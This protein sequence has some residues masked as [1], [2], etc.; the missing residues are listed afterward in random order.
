MTFGC[1]ICFEI[2]S[3]GVE[4]Q[5]ESDIVSCMKR[6]TEQRHFGSAGIYTAMEYRRPVSLS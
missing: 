1:N 2:S 6:G 3:A 5:L 4:F